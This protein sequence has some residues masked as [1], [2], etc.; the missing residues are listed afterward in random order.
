MNVS[1][2]IA[3][4][5]AQVNG[6]GPLLSPVDRVSEVLFGLIMALTFTGTLSVAEADRTE[7]RSMLIGALGCNIAWG[8]VDGVMFLLA[9]L[10]ERGRNLAILKEVRNASD[11]TRARELILDALPPIIAS[12][13]QPQEV[14]ALRARL[15]GLPE[16]GR[17]SLTAADFRLAL[18]V[19]LLVFLATLPV[20]LPF[21]FIQEAQLALRVSNGIALLMLFIGGYYLGRHGGRRPW[22][23]GLLMLGIGVVLVWATIALGG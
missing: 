23:G 7:V 9:A 10:T 11:P 20:A 2:S 13:M 3:G 5:S 18:G 22:V 6:P 1:S 21:A 15:A 16:P 8:L 17:Y 14:D 19:F 12:T 4:S